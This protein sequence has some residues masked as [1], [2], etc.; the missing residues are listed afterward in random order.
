M[1]SP[2]ELKRRTARL[3]VISNTVLVILK[4]IVGL[5]V[6]AMSLVSEAMHSGV[7]LIAS[8]LAFWTVKKAGEPPD[9]EHDYGHGKF[10]NLSSAAEAL[11]IILAALGIVYEAVEKFG[12]GA[13]TAFLEYGIAIMA[14]SIVI[15]YFVSRRLLQVAKETDSQA[16]EADGLHLAADIWTSVG[17]LLGLVMMKLTGWLWL[18]SV[19]AIAVAGIIFHAGAK[20]LRASLQELTDY[21]LPAG[22]EARLTKILTSRREVLDCHALRTRKSGSRKILDAHLVFADDMPL[23]DVHDICNEL[24]H[25]VRREFGD[26]DVLIHPEP[27]H[28]CA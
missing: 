4:L 20:M 10:E 26:C 6:G 5:A 23:N 2:D 12:T 17:V 11:L 16:L 19:I 1:S 7:D 24:E 21:S 22:E 25:K 27:L 3:S 18:D 9:V 13:D 28:D 14:V 8:L 15:N